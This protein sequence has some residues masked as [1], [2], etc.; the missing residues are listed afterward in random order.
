M[1]IIH[2]QIRVKSGCIEAFQA[3]TLA[4]ARASI[5]EPGI[6]RFDVVQQQDDPTRFVLVEVYRA[7]EDQAQHRLTA[8]YAAWAGAVVDMMAEPRSALKYT[9]VFPGEDGW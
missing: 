1:H 3:A 5:Q 8:H 4:N 2:V 9:N 6:L 7:A